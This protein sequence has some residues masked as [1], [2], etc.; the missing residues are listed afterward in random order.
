M[1]K[2]RLCRAGA[3]ALAVVCF[4]LVTTHAQAIPAT[5]PQPQ[6][7]TDLLV[8]SASH[9]QV[10]QSPARQATPIHPV[11]PPVVVPPVKPPAPT[12][13]PPEPQPPRVLPAPVYPV[14]TPV[15]RPPANPPVVS[16]PPKPPVSSV[17]TKPP[18]GVVTPPENG[19]GPVPEASTLELLVKF[20][21]GNDERLFAQVGTDLNIQVVDQ[22]PQLGVSVVRVVSSTPDRIPQA[23]RLMP[24]IAYVEPNYPVNIL[25]WPNDPDVAVQ[26]HLAA[27]EAPAAWDMATGAGVVVG[28][29]DTGVD[30]SER[31]LKD[32]IVPGYDFVNDDAEPWDDQGHG[33]R[34]AAIVAAA[35]NNGYGGV[36]VAYDA[37]V[38]PLKA[39]NNTGSGRHAWISKAIIWATDHD[40]DVINLS[41]GGPYHSQT[42]QDAV[43][44]AWQH[45]VLLVAAAGNESTNIPV[46]PAAYD[47]VLAVA[48]TTRDQQRA[49]FSNWGD[50]VAVAAPGTNILVTS[51]GN[52]QMRNG[53]SFAAPQVSGV[54]SL[55]LSR[56]PGLTASQ[57]RDIIQTTA[58]DLGSQGW[59]PFYGFGQ[60]NAYQAV[61]QARHESGGPNPTTAVVDAVNHARQ[62][63]DL[64]ALRADDQ[65]MAAVQRR[66]ESLTS[67]CM[68]S[69]EAS[70]ASCVTRLGS[71]T[72]RS[73]VM[74]V[75]VSSPQAVVDLLA[76]STA[77]QELLFGPYWQIGVGYV[78][79][80]RGPISQVWVLR[81][82][83]E[84][85]R[86]PH[87]PPI[88]VTETDH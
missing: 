58:N 44:Y 5:L 29:I 77:G 24:G 26:W 11:E 57:V 43:N 33:T 54:A 22:I 1:N 17:P 86:P 42:L 61:L 83:Q 37:Q 25:G 7:R 62:L 53:T 40:A 64:P 51:G 70:L 81:F 30:P 80:G 59:D 60:V 13:V 79:A 56:N 47:P 82:A 23:L 76:V 12:A 78:E 28:V 16:H 71:S 14:K 8:S 34:I 52:H 39:L 2:V 74:L 3:L 88:P 50:Y 45:G 67:R 68:S 9:V 4:T 31:D 21:V 36:G 75:G 84:R 18:V 41:I 20:E 19:G 48:G 66:A 15:P 6:T 85:V 65:L 73:E 72:H 55:V 63:R 38:M 27:I 10:A 49:G 32:K 69:G 35:A 46:Y 87:G